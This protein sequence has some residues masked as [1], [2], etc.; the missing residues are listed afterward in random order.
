MIRAI[1][2]RRRSRRVESACGGDDQP[3]RAELLSLEQLK[4]H[5]KE[6]APKHTVDEKRGR[7]SHVRRGG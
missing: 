7:D 6:L 3:L 4:E 5:A 2:D 1:W